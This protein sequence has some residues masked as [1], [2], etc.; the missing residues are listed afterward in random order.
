MHSKCLYNY[1]LSWSKNTRAIFFNTCIL[2]SNPPPPTQTGSPDQ[3]LSDTEIDGA[4]QK[5]D[6]QDDSGNISLSRTNSSSD[7]KQHLHQEKVKNKRSHGTRS[8]TSIQGRGDDEKTPLLMGNIESCPVFC[9]QYQVKK[10]RYGLCCGAT[11]LF[12]ILALALALIGG[13]RWNSVSINISQ[14]EVDVKKFAVRNETLF[15]GKV[16]ASWVSNATVSECTQYGDSSHI[17]YVYVVNQEDLKMYTVSKEDGVHTRHE[18]YPWRT[19]YLLR[20]YFWGG[21]SFNLSFHAMNP[22]GSTG[23]GYVHIFNDEDQFE[24][25]KN[26]EPALPII[27]KQLNIGTFNVSEPTL[28]QYKVDQPSFYFIAV[29]TPADVYYSYL[30]HSKKVYLDSMDY[31][32]SCA[33]VYEG[34]PCSLKFTKAGRYFVLA[35]VK[36]LVEEGSFTT[37]LCLKTGIVQNAQQQI[38]QYKSLTFTGLGVIGL[39]L[40]IFVSCI[41]YHSR[42]DNVVGKNM[43]SFS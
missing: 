21:S 18:L 24:N 8:Q 6:D 34:S 30:F 25:Y 43:K 35:Y 42:R 31:E 39:C 16:D 5:K 22:A 27:S 23:I 7:S 17:S 12:V 4:L 29:E 41:T 26:G 38:I 32:K 40:L 3:D 36:P 13:L 33:Q 28:F 14:N 37:H 20:D 15:L 1:F 2:L 19:T 10:T 11:S 9:V